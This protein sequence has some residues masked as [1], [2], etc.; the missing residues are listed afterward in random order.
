MSADHQKSGLKV[1]LSNRMCQSSPSLIHQ[2]SLSNSARVT[3]A[4]K[5][6]RVLEEENES[7]RK[8]LADLRALYKQLLTEGQHET[9]DERRVMLLKS[10]VI[11]LERQMILLTAALGSRSST[12]IEVENSVAAVTDFCKSLLQHRDSCREI[13]VSHADIDR[14]IAT[15]ESARARLF[16]AAETT[17]DDAI[18]QPLA[19]IGD[20]IRN[21]PDCKVVTLFD[22][23]RGGVDHINLRH[24][25]R[26]ETK[27]VALYKQ[28]T[29]VN[30]ALRVCVQSTSPAAR[31]RLPD[32]PTAAF[33]RLSGHVSKSCEMLERV[34]CDL[35]Q[36]SLLVPSAPFPVHDRPFLGE[37]TVDN[38]MTALRGSKVRDVR[39]LVEAMVKAMNHSLHV[40]SADKSVLLNE[41]EFHR[42]VY[43]H[44]SNYA[45]SLLAAF[46]D[47]FAK[48]ETGI[49]EKFRQPLTSILSSFEQLK[50]S[51]SHESLLS[52][53][54]VFDKNTAVLDD[55][56]HV[57]STG[58][59]SA[60]RNDLLYVEYKKAL[61]DALKTCQTN[62]DALVDEIALVKGQ[63]QEQTS[64]LVRKVN[65]QDKCKQTFRDNA[66]ND[67]RDVVSAAGMMTN[68]VDSSSCQRDNVLQSPVDRNDEKSPKTLITASDENNYGHGSQ[69][70]HKPRLGKGASQ[71]VAPLMLPK[72]SSRAAAAGPVP[73][74]AQQKLVLLSN[75]DDSRNKSV[76]RGE[77]RTTLDD[78]SAGRL[79]TR[80]TGVDNSAVAAA[81]RNT[82]ELPPKSVESDRYS[83]AARASQKGSKAE[84]AT[85]EF[86]G[87]L[88]RMKRSSSV[89]FR[90]LPSDKNVSRTSR[91]H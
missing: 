27:L 1:S 79:I 4:E 47:A 55:T 50:R 68:A 11:Q 91:K 61:T 22:V 17:S 30:S 71:T 77:N 88:T 8:E 41:L 63:L 39:P 84:A 67:A 33:S 72:S 44:Q 18:A 38:V 80:Y 26:L 45:D 59:E 25:G 69:L 86:S 53:I 2:P 87:Q 75:N 12:L 73:G 52:F 15:L 7:L 56:V 28:L 32:V 14:V 66:P 60:E 10:Q 20:F 34:C 70:S 40:A 3:E 57:L 9:F 5:T 90:D 74:V 46:D 37:I 24:V 23:C 58:T 16:R 78:G 85:P 29:L 64:E 21:R 42:C 51:L 13:R 65:T 54:D 49:E 36:L 82:R 89:H 6:I 76:T 62:R 81:D 83:V 43:E 31:C 19:M 35:L 48:F